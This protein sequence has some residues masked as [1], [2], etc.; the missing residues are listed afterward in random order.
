M[1]FAIQYTIDVNNINNSFQRPTKIETQ[2]PIFNPMGEE[3]FKSIRKCLTH[4]VLTYVIIISIF[5]ISL[6][7]IEII[8]S[9]TNWNTNTCSNET[10]ILPTTWLIVD[11]IF[12]CITTAIFM[13]FFLFEVVFQQKLQTKCLLY[14]L[15]VFEF[16][17]TI[18]GAVVLWRDNISCSP[19]DLD[20][21]FWTSIIVKLFIF[22]HFWFI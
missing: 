5:I 6:S 14:L 8:I 19:L 18:I 13:K 15:I 1:D 3:G 17:W 7:I 12:Q 22:L 9:G 21:I 10:I 20:I 2:D 4:F 16:I 11:G